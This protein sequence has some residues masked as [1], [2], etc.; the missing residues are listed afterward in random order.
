MSILLY[1]AENWPVTKED[2]RKLTTFHMRCLRDILGFTLWH[3]RRNADV[4]RETEE[5]PIE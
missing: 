2:I 1:E 5:H 4:L 3:K